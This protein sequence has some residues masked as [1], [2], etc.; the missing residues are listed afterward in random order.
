MV[1]IAP[2]DRAKEITLTM[3]VEKLPRGYVLIDCEQ[4]AAV[5][6]DG[7]ETGFE[8]P[9]LGIRVATGPHMIQLVDGS[10]RRSPIVKV[11]VRQGETVRI[12]MAIEEG[13]R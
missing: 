1:H 8:T 10:G 5:W 12:K 11:N 4:S 2:D 7:A 9:T 13:K 3:E 6:I